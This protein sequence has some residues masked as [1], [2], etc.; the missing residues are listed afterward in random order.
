M[1]YWTLRYWTAYRLLD[2]RWAIGC[3][4]YSVGPPEP[5]T[6]EH[7]V[8]HIFEHV[9]MQQLKPFRVMFNSDG[10]KCDTQYI[11]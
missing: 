9:F 2:A 8:E 10:D 7:K 11:K 4:S 1:G 3:C 6:E 5:E